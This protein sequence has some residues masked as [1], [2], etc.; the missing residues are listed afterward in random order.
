[1]KI[2]SIDV[3]IRNLAIC[4]VNTGTGKSKDT[5]KIE[6][7]RVINLLQEE[8]D[9]IASKCKAN[10]CESVNKNGKACAFSAKFK[11]GGNEA[12]KVKVCKKHLASVSSNSGSDSKVAVTPIADPKAK[13]KKVKALDIQKLCEML[14]STLIK[15]SLEEY[16]LFG[17]D[18]VIIELQPKLNPK[19]KNLSNMMYACFII[20]G[21]LGGNTKKVLYVNAKHKLRTG[22]SGPFIDTQHLKGKY[23]KTKYTGRKQCEW[24]LE[25]DSLVQKEQVEDEYKSEPTSTTN[26][27]FFRSHK[28][29]D[30]LADSFLQCVWYIQTKHF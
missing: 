6:F 19:M 29:Q 14:C 22:Y 11:V 13:K 26:L 23:A 4:V 5:D 30:D 7:W 25:Q 27:D 3:G 16:N 21:V 10:K 18:H 28:K 20:K 9:T 8:D 17:A 2:V 15:I 1:M 24:Y 12:D